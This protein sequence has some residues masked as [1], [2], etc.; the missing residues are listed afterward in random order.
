MLYY[1]IVFFFNLCRPDYEVTELT[2][3]NGQLSMHGLGLPRVPEKPISASRKTIPSSKYTW[4]KPHGNGTLE[5][6]V[7]QAT[8]VPHHTKSVFDV[9]A[10]GDGGDLVPWFD[11]KRAAKSNTLTMDGMVPCSNRRDEQKT[12]HVV[13]LVPSGGT[14]HGRNMLGYSA[15]VGSCDGHT[16]QDEETLLPSKNTT[17]AR[18]PVAVDWSNKS[19]S[20]SVSGSA[21]CGREIQRVM[22]DSCEKESGMALISTS[23]GSPENTSSEKQCT[24]T[25]T[26]DDYDSISLSIPQ[27]KSFVTHPSTVI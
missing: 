17:V 14:I 6:I 1:I 23:M 3:E 26:I 16:N 15:R 19:L 13:D 24:K 7:N 18:V 12:I 27:V 25:T 9:G 4:D 21:T 8:H 10:T 11:P 22:L 2:W 5:S 20:V